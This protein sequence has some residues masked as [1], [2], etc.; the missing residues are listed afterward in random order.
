MDTMDAK[1]A[2]DILT[3]DSLLLLD[4]IRRPGDIVYA[5]HW[6]RAQIN[7]NLQR[8]SWHQIFE[9]IYWLLIKVFRPSGPDSL[10]GCSWWQ[11]GLGTHVGDTWTTLIQPEP[12]GSTR[13]WVWWWWSN[14]EVKRTYSLPP[15][16]VGGGC[17]MPPSSLAELVKR[18]FRYYSKI[19]QCSIYSIET[20]YFTNNKEKEIPCWSPPLVFAS[21]TAIFQCRHL[22]AGSQFLSEKVNTSLWNTGLW[23]HFLPGELTEG[24]D[25]CLGWWKAYEAGL[26]RWRGRVALLQIH[27]R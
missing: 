26:G 18:D 16:P 27:P 24:G 12:A 25:W 11:S 13:P 22:V 23:V 9:E 1:V 19:L 21:L 6:Q 4:I 2:N 10:P 17:T 7:L 14:L 3:Y 8:N 15:H 5:K 20:N